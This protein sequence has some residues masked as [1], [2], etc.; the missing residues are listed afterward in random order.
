MEI[1]EENELLPP[2]ESEATTITE[3]DLMEEL[4]HQLDSLCRCSEQIIEAEGPPQVQRAWRERQ[5]QE[6]ESLNCLK[7][8]AAEGLEQGVPQE[9]F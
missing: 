1:L 6:T 2:K 7:Q 8:K 3:H 9:G 4:H 5:K